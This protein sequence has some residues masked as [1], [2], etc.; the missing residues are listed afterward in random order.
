MQDARPRR[1]LRSAMWSL[2]LA[3]GGTLVVLALVVVTTGGVLVR[4]DR[5]CP[6]NVLGLPGSVDWADVVA[7]GG[8]EHGVVGDTGGPTDVSADE[9]GRQLVEVRCRVADTLSVP[10]RVGEGEATLLP[11]G[12][13]VHALRGGGPDVVA[14]LPD[15]TRL[16]YAPLE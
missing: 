7:V 9:V 10:Y 1:P 12:T 13:T 11:V 5:G 14:V 6:R 16:R 8:V 3:L 2:G 4:D 15:G